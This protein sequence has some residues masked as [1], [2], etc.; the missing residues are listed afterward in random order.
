MFEPAKRNA[1]YQDV[2]D[3]PEHLVAELID[4]D[5]FLS[6]RPGGPHTGVASALGHLLGPPFQFGAGGPGG[7]IILD[8]PELHFLEKQRVVAPDMAGWRRERMPEV[9]ATAYF[10][11]VPDWICEVLSPSNAMH[12][13]SKKLPL[14]AAN[15]VNHFW[16]V[17]PLQRSV[18]IM[19]L[20]GGKYVVLDVH[21]GDGRVRVE[22]FD[23][24]ELDLS[25]LWA[26]LPKP[27]PTRASEIAAEYAARAA[28]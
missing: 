21:Q 23:A 24:I 10:T 4:G 26:T 16:L 25:L 28:Q 19:R 2:L 14:Y 15:G 8:E 18:E 1:T 7:W 13:R 11:I 9:T 5:L 12:D 20:Q 6:P 27:Q 22:P 17:D 3:A